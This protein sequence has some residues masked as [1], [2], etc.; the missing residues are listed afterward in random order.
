MG[1]LYMVATPIGNLDDITL[2]ALNTLKNVDIIACEDTRV[3]SALLTHH[4]ISGKKLITLASHNEINSSKGIM[5]LLEEG[6]DVALCTDRGTPGI[7]DP[8]ERVVEEAHQNGF[9]VIP[10]PG[11]SAVTTLISASGNIGKTWTF[12]GFLPKTS[13]KLNKRLNELLSAPNSFVIYESPFRV[14][15][16][17]KVILDIAPLR[18][19][20]IGRELT[21]IHEEIIKGTVTEIYESLSKRD[22]IKG[23]FAII[24][25]AN[26]DNNKNDTNQ[27]SY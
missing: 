2:R 16:T 5:K 22:S 15:K 11:V 3:T 6:R 9:D 19:I 14:L 20:V 12:E 1:K 17:L 8:G 10:I 26:T 25:C 4:G 27:E 18:Q 23:E 21:K 7:S 24:V 13:G